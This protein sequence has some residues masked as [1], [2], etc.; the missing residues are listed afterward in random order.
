MNGRKSKAIRKIV[1]ALIHDKKDE[2][3]QACIAKLLQPNRFGYVSENME[4]PV[5]QRR[6]Q[7]LII[8]P[9]LQMKKAVKKLDL[10]ASRA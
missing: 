2:V 10:L 7:H 9:I 1:A 8:S 5:N 3:T 6:R 4:D